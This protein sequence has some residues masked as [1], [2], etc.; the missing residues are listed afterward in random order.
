M[1][2]P[3]PGDEA[4]LW[5]LVWDAPPALGRLE[6]FLD[7]LTAEER[8]RYERHV[9]DS[10]RVEYLLTRA[11]VRTV[12]SHYADVAPWD[13]RFEEGE[14]GRPALCGPL[15]PAALGFNLSNTSGMIVC[16]VDG[17][18]RSVGVDVEDTRRP[19]AADLAER[20]F[21]PREIR[22]LRALPARMQHDRFYEYWTLKEAYIKARGLG[23]ALPLEHFSFLP[24]GERW[25]VEFDE[26]VRDDA[27]RWQFSLH[28]PTG[29]H[30]VALAIDRGSGPEVTVATRDVDIATLGLS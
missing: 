28:R 15:A 8:S 16:L 11:V 29:N 1:R 3:L 10:V 14:Y 25:M 2:L 7:W 24:D 20:C 13:W 12:L 19:L 22:T 5:Q 30:V 21:S 6:R 4:H 18:G 27:R 23:L 9:V 26:R 17:A